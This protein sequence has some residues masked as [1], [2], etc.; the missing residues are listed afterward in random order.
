MLFA[1]EWTHKSMEQKG[2]A[3]NS[4]TYKFHWIAKGSS[5]RNDR[6]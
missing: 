5:L 3:R 2:E 6:L 4:P 1:R